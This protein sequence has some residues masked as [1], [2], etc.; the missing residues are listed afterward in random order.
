MKCPVCQQTI[1]IYKLP[2]DGSY[3]CRSCNN[4][5]SI[6]RCVENIGDLL[7]WFITEKGTEVLKDKEK[8]IS[9]AKDLFPKSKQDIR[10]LDKLFSNGLYNLL[11]SNNCTPYVK[12]SNAEQTIRDFIKAQ[13]NMESEYCSGFYDFISTAFSWNI[14]EDDEA[15]YESLENNSVEE[16]LN[17]ARIFAVGLERAKDYTKVYHCLKKASEMGSLIAIRSIPNFMHEE[18]IQKGLESAISQGSIL[19]EGDLLK[20]YI[21]CGTSEDVERQIGHI[22]DKNIV[23]TVIEA[24]IHLRVRTGMPGVLMNYYFDNG[25]AEESIKKEFLTILEEPN[26]LKDTNFK[27]KCYFKYIN[28]AYA[29]WEDESPNGKAAGKAWWNAIYSDATNGDTYAL[30]LCLLAALNEYP[31]GVY[32]FSDKVQNGIMLFLEAL[33]DES[34]ELV[35]FIKLYLTTHRQINPDLYRQMAHEGNPYAICEFIKTRSSGTK[36]KT[37]TEAISE[38]NNDCELCKVAVLMFPKIPQYLTY[39]IDWLGKVQNTVAHKEIY[40]IISLFTDEELASRTRDLS[41]VIPFLVYGLGGGSKKHDLALTILESVDNAV[42]LTCNSTSEFEILLNS[43]NALYMYCAES[44]QMSRGLALKKKIRELMEKY[45]DST[46]GKSGS[47]AFYRSVFALYLVD[48]NLYGDGIEQSIDKSIVYANIAK[49]TFKDF[50]ILGNTFVAT[51]ALIRY[52]NNNYNINALS[53]PKFALARAILYFSRNDYQNAYNAFNESFEYH[54]AHNYSN[55]IVMYMYGKLLEVCQI[56][57]EYQ[58]ENA[59]KAFSVSYTAGWLEALPYYAYRSFMSNEKPDPDECNELFKKLL[60]FCDD[61]YPTAC[62]AVYVAFCNQLIAEETKYMR[63]TFLKKA[64]ELRHPEA[65]KHLIYIKYR[66]DVLLHGKNNCPQDLPAAFEAYMG[67]ALCGDIVCCNNVGILYLNGY[68]VKADSIEA[69]K[70]LT[71]AAEKENVNSV[72]ELLKLYQAQQNATALTKIIFLTRKWSNSL[73]KAQVAVNYLHN[74]LW[75]DEAEKM[76][77][78]CAENGVSFAAA[79]YAIC[80]FNNGADNY[81]SAEQWAKKAVAGGYSGKEK[82]ALYITNYNAAINEIASIETAI[83]QK[84]NELGNLGIFSGRRKK[85]L[86]EDIAQLLTRLSTENSKLDSYMNVLKSEA[87]YTY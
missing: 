65:E 63:Y 73:N 27:K 74:N 61:N 26:R 59:K 3:Q 18:D 57:N 86:S 87:V 15:F 25:Y 83:A 45:V 36:P 1:S 80:L 68:G 24:E 11:I 55:H 60:P 8:I 13:L 10:S 82:F 52:A 31:E 43:L 37:Y 66:A 44:D 50:N 32:P 38:F 48:C 58:Y 75:A 85:E 7:R 29:F 78:E 4:T 64:L 77:R 53:E 20:Y 17:K 62:I 72:M 2:S 34:K 6:I 69:E 12:N 19:A 16:L 49:E 79:Y 28:L 51:T 81:N 47:I 33:P 39:H 42:W 23:Y 14:A 76:L 84:K 21:D 9:Y 5:I 71:V 70:W 35:K 54:Q 40:R 46:A 41:T 56:N 30:Q 22:I 67:G